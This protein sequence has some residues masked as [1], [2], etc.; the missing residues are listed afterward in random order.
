M[1][2]T[3]WRAAAGLLGGLLWLALAL[4][5]PVGARA[6]QAYEVF[7]NRLWT[8]ALL[9][10]LA[11]WRGP[12]LA[13][14]AAR[15]AWAVGR[16]GLGLMAA[17]NFSEYWLL[18]DL[19]HAGPLGFARGLAWMTVLLGW[20]LTLSAALA[21]GLVWLKTGAGPAWLSAVLIGA[22][23]LTLG[24]GALSLNWAGVPLGLA[25]LAVGLAVWQSGAP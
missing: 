24:L 13:R 1:T 12:A 3:R 21:A 11:G 18:S 5:P 6:T 19:P 15:T 2:A 22:W 20:L 14:G 25:G 17:G 16:A 10:L 23:P 9:G 8:P 4:I 7:W